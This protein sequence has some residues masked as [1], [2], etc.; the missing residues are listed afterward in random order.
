[1]HSVLGWV[2][3]PTSAPVHRGQSVTQTGCHSARRPVGE[4]KGSN[5]KG[6]RIKCVFVSIHIIVRTRIQL[7]LKVRTVL[8][9]EDIFFWSSQLQWAIYEIWLGFKDQVRVLVEVRVWLELQWGAGECIMSR[10]VLTKIELQAC[11]NVCVCLCVLMLMLMMMLKKQVW[12]FIHRLWAKHR[13]H[14][15][16][17]IIPFLIRKTQYFDSSSY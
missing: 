16:S 12:L 2:C 10:R 7:S 6:F 5:P 13:L 11:M 14:N 17:K 3:V 4:K 8:G 1:M 15:Y 9:Y